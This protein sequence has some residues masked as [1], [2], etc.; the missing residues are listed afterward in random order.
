MNCI[1]PD[2][3]FVVCIDQLSGGP[4]VFYSSYT[5]AGYQWLLFIYLN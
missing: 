1:Q 5:I 4:G 2:E 3:D